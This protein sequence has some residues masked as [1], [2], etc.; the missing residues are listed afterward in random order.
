MSQTQRISRNNTKVLT[1][2]GLHNNQ[3]QVWLYNT[4]VVTVTPDEII[5]NTE[6]WYTVTTRTRLNQVSNEWG[7]GYGVSFAGKPS[8]RYQGHVY[9]FDD[10]DQVR[11]A[12]KEQ[13]Q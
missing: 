1:N 6:G 12:R 8:V 3:R 2:T 7:L 10:K 4:C 11:L 9:D 13:G 5:L